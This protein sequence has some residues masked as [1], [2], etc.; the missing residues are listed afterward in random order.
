MK[1]QSREAGDLPS[2]SSLRG[3]RVVNTRSLDQALELDALLLQ[4]GA[5]PL[6]YPCIGIAPSQNP[7]ALDSALKDLAAGRFD[8]LVFT[9]SNAVRAVANAVGAA[10]GAGTATG[11]SAAAGAATSA[12][13]V[14]SAV[15]QGAGVPD[16]AAALS[17]AALDTGHARVAAVGPGTAQAARRLL[18]LSVDLE[19]EVYTAEALAV[20]L[21][22]QEPGRVLIPLGDQARDTLPRALEANGA[23]VTSVTAYH[24]VLG[25]GGVNLPEILRRGKV[26][27]IAFTSPSTVDNLAV[28]LEREGGDW[29]PVHSACIACIGPVTSQ[30]AANRGLRVHAQAREHTM[31]GLVDALEAC[32]HTSSK[33]E[34][35]NHA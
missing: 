15:A 30:A 35:S 14:R 24:T 21:V 3:K 10:T 19:P 17:A 26:D 18:A 12:A 6:S 27:A 20:E 33:K 7:A 29:S 25:Q 11:A 16:A 1:E 9:S 32:F 13:A 4:R 8:W 34:G 5:L 28:R 2:A 23:R 31:R 22:A